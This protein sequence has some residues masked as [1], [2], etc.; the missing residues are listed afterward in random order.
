MIGRRG[1]TRGVRVARHRREG[2][3]RTRDE[4]AVEEP[5]EIRV[6]R[7]TNEGRRVSEALAVTMR[8][9]GHD[10][11]LVA[12]FLHGEGVVPSAEAL[13]ELTYCLGR[14]PEGP[15]RYN[16]VEARLAPGVVFDAEALRRNFFTSS[17]CGVCG[18]ASLESVEAR[19]CRP[20][21]SDLTLEADVLASL[22]ERLREG[23]GV[24]ARTGGLHAAGLF[25]ADGTCSAVREDVGRHNA[26]DKAVG[27]ALLHRA[28]PAA[29]R[30]LVVSGRASFEILQKAVTAGV[31][32]VVAVGAPSSLAVDLAARF[33]VTLAG[34][35]RNGAFNVY[36]GE[37]R[38]H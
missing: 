25:A 4:L 24:F 12:G 33:G 28:L 5:L 18:K 38:I 15:Q 6:S 14:D 31:P 9:P 30:V 3:E 7:V 23:Q 26:V 8:T 19:G 20:V 37:G 35:A 21:E 1:A 29:D 36:T 22:P 10:F 2:V 32:V 27:Y 34:F 11:E 17:S 13:Q 16:V